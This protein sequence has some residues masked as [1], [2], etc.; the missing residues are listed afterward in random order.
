MG[1]ENSGDYSK[2]WSPPQYE[3]DGDGKVIGSYA[4]SGINNWGR[5]GEDDEIGTQ[6]LIGP[7]QRK[8]AV[9]TV[10]TG[11]VFLSRFQLILKHHVFILGLL[12]SIGL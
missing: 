9:K 5:W 11:R 3:V 8:E 7:D 10:K 1:R 2:K 6:N 4:P 12:L